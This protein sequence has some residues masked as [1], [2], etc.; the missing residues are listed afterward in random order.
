ML[1]PDPA[2]LLGPNVPKR[3]NVFSR[4]VGRIGFRLLGFHFD[5]AVPDVPRFVMIVAPHTSNWDFLVG[6]MAKLAL[7]LRAR[8][9]AKHT[10]FWEPFG[11]FLR[12]MGGIPVN[13][14][15]PGGIIQAVVEAFRTS[16]RLCV[17]IAPEGTRRKVPAWKSGFHRIAHGAG[18][19]ILPVAFDYRK[20]AIVFEP[21]FHTTGDYEADLKALQAG[22]SRE[23]AYRPERY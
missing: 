10:L 9:I 5:G 14:H 11:S 7:G 17:V 16:D 12:W 23:M 19:P 21:L 3:G 8:F 2:S 18:V 1:G 6:I 13:R 20:R 22:F 15:A 4:A